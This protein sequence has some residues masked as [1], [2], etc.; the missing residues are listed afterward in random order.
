MLIIAVDMPFVKPFFRYFETFSPGV[1]GG[2]KQVN[3][4][5]FLP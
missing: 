1:T 2:E 3:L 4:G 5:S